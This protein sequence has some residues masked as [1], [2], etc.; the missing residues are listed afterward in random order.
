MDD[1]E[2]ALAGDDASLVLAG[3]SLSSSSTCISI[4]ASLWRVHA[5]F[6]RVP[7]KGSSALRFVAFGA[8]SAE[9]GLQG[10]AEVPSRSSTFADC[11][12]ATLSRYVLGR[13]G[14]R[15]RLTAFLNCLCL[16]LRSFFHCCSPRLLTLLGSRRSLP[17]TCSKDERSVGNIFLSMISIRHFNGPPCFLSVSV[18]VSVSVFLSLSLSLL[19]SFS[20]SSSQWWW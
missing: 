16:L 14:P 7:S 17:S 6:L 9:T 4:W 20:F 5:L 2:A 19:P 11:K 8:L 15:M 1:D 18:S 10:A 13:V 3:I 12:N